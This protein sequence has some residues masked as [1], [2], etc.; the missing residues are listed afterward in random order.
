ML[1]AKAA[2]SSAVSAEVNLIGF[3]G[4]GMPG[5]VEQAQPKE[6]VQHRGRM[7]CGLPRDEVWQYVP[8]SS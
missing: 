5:N 8:Q 2:A 7:L 1:G 4:L 3:L 6:R